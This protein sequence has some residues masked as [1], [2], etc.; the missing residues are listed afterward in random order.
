M[1]EAAAG[2]AN[3]LPKSFFTDAKFGNRLLR[4]SYQTDVTKWKPQPL[5]S[6][7]IH[8]F[9]TEIYIAPLQG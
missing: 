1:M 9:I 6:T 3:D 8:S 5:I 4:L 2:V 7:L